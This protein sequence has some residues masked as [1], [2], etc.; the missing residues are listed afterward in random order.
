MLTMAWL[1]VPKHEETNEW[2]TLLKETG[3]KSDEKGARSKTLV[4]LGDH[5]ACRA[6]RGKSSTARLQTARNVIFVGDGSTGK[7]TLLARLA[8]KEAAEE[9]LGGNALSYSYMEVHTD[10]AD[11]D[12]DLRNP[13]RMRGGVREQ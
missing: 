11:F 6:S 12:G 4:C 3:S 9:V 7:R 5:S 1:A 13:H 2:E 8:N 10:E